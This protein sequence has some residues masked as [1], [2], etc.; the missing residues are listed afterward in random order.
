MINLTVVTPKERS[1]VYPRILAAINYFGYIHNIPDCTCQ[2]PCTD[3]KG[4]TYAKLQDDSGKSVG[5]ILTY[6]DEKGVKH[7]EIYDNE[8]KVAVE[9]REYT[10][11]NK[12]EHYEIYDKCEVYGKEGKQVFHDVLYTDEKKVEHYEV[13]N[14]VGKLQFSNL[15]Y[16]DKDGNICDENY[17]ENNL[18]EQ[19][20]IYKG[21]EKYTYIPKALLVF[22]ERKESYKAGKLKSIYEEDR[23]SEDRL[24]CVYR[25]LEGKILSRGTYTGDK[26]VLADMSHGKWSPL[27]NLFYYGKWGKIAGV[28][29]NERRKAANAQIRKISKDVTLLDSEKQRKMREVVALYRDRGKYKTSN[30][31]VGAALKK[32]LPQRR[33]YDLD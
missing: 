33:V 4:I 27:V 17:D 12:V 16:I 1:L 8:N 21:K 26:L 15:R 14:D 7:H 18:L 11:E 28:K 5:K 20:M 23:S 2:E 13:Y 9:G 31:K 29:L 3:E 10:D 25:N 22:M 19:R 6:V 24:V 30:K 32:Y